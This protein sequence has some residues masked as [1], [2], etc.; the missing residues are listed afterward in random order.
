MVAY[1]PGPSSSSPHFTC[2]DNVFLRSVRCQTLWIGR[3][4]GGLY[5][6]PSPSKRRIAIYPKHMHTITLIELN[7]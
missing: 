2:L 3:Y 7:Q 6:S 5:L 4:G 1:G